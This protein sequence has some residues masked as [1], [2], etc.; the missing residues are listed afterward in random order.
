[1]DQLFDICSLRLIHFLLSEK[2]GKLRVLKISI[3][4]LNWQSELFFDGVLEVS[5][6]NV[7]GST[8]IIDFK[9]HQHHSNSTK[10]KCFENLTM[11]RIFLFKKRIKLLNY[12]LSQI[13][14]S[15]NP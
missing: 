8:T 12:S 1:M 9:N 3:K 5:I 14:C 7:D 13:L 4:N 6:L 15:N 11:F 2:G 10:E